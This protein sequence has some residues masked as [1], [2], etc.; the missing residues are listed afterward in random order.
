M[1]NGPQGS[2]PTPLALD[3]SV[4]LA[5]LADHRT[6]RGVPDAELQWLAAHGTVYHTEPGDLLLKLPQTYESMTVL[7]S[8]HFAI[9]VDHGAGP[10]KVMEWRGGDITGFL[11]YS[12]MSNKPIGEMV[13]DEAGDALIIHMRHFPEMIRECP[14]VT[15]RVVHI[16][17][18]RA[19]HFRS[20]ELQDEK[21]LSLG[22]LAAGLAH[23]LNNP[24]SA[25]ARSAKLLGDGL[26]EAEA[27]SRA[28]GAARL[29]DA[30][31]EAVEAARQVC[32]MAPASAL[33]PVA[34]ADRED[35]IADWLRTHRGNPDA[36]PA[37]ADTAVTI[38]SLDSL[39]RLLDGETL[40]T[41][42]RWV[43][44]G[45]TTR[46]L[47]SEVERAATRIHALVGAVKRFTY[48][49]RALAPD[50][51]DVE[52]SVNDAVALLVHKARK[53]SVG[54]D[55]RIEAD[56]PR[57][58]AIGGDLS[59]V[60]T[61]LIDN[62]IDAVPHSGHVVVA[63]A[64]HRDFVTVRVVDDGSGIPGEIRD[65]IFDPFFTSK[66]VGQ[67]TGLGLDIARQLVRR[68]NGDIEVDSEPGRTEFRVTLRVAPAQAI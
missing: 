7:L 45:C 26:A 40:Q 49:D 42:L 50:A 67:G 61:N 52:A 29:T 28:L 12:R 1:T 15:T 23:E 20:S 33:D 8:G 6:L 3:H 54:I 55:V 47:A 21:M 32:A 53:K 16:M 2:A 56:L 5:R 60:W 66:P 37:L 64:S 10:H 38:Q 43:A 48:M 18:D 51:I 13:V 68:N 35:A 44:A 24:A 11:P 30:Q 65:R 22:K 17:V 62:A 9:Y 46:A 31:L 57:V 19:R 39:A 59:Q 41:A 4:L 63:A 14:T 58:C 34:R 36:A 25:A 27:A